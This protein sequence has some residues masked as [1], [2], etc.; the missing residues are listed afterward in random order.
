MMNDARTGSRS[1]RR[2]ALW[3]AVAT[4]L[5]GHGLLAQ[6]DASVTLAWDPSP[7][8]TV[9][10][11]IVHYGNASGQYSASTNVGNVTTATV[12]DLQVGT[13]YFFAVTAYDT[14]GLESDPSNEVSYTPT[15]ANAVTLVAVAS[16]TPASGTAPL[17]V[18]FDG[19]GSAV[20]G[21]SA[22]S[23][24]WTF[25]D[26]TTASGLTVQHTYQA[27]GPYTAVL[28]VTSGVGAT[29]LTNVVVSA[30]PPPMPPVAVA[31][32]TP[33]SGVVPFTVAFDGSASSAS[34]GSLVAYQWDFGD[35]TSA[36][37]ATVQHSY[38]TAGTYTAVLTVT[39]SRGASSTA[40]VVIN[41]QPAST[42]LSV[43]LAW[44]ASPD[45]TVAGYNVHY[46][47]ASGHY[48]TALNVGKQTTAQ[49]SGLQAGQTYFF[50]V[51]A[52]DNTGLES[53]PSNEVSYNPTAAPPK[54]TTPPVLAGVPANVTVQAG[55]LPTAPVVT[56]TDNADPAPVV[57]LTETKSAGT[58][59][60]SYQLVRTW[61]ATDAC[62]NHASASQTITVQD[63]TP[64][65]LAGVP[66]NVT[67][68]AGALPTA[69]LVTATDN[70]DPA[71]LV[72]LTETTVTNGDSQSY[73]LVRTWTAT[74]ACGNYASTAQTIT[75]QAV[76]PP[77]T[78]ANWELVGL[79]GTAIHFNSAALLSA[80]ASTDPTNWF[81]LASLANGSLAG[82][83]VGV[84]ADGTVS[85]LPPSGFAG[86]D[87]YYYSLSNSAGTTLSMTGSVQVVASLTEPAVAIAHPAG[88]A[89]VSLRGEVPLTATVDD[90]NG[91]VV[92]VE[93]YVHSSLVA[94]ATNRDGNSFS[95]VW[96]G[97]R[98]G[99]WP[100]TATA[101]T[102]DGR[103]VGSSPRKFSLLSLA[104]PG[105]AAGP[106]VIEES[107]DG[108]NWTVVKSFFSG[109][110]LS[111]TTPGALNFEDEQTGPARFY[112]V[113][114]L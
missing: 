89:V 11:Y 34:G 107:A 57:T 23:Y 60:Q 102:S 17:T 21:A 7:D 5:A 32:A 59:P 90:S 54:D 73:T 2:A 52:Y 55:A 6:T 38:L 28:T 74:D 30:L 62:G 24:Q 26:G 43:T 94:V 53:D 93:F 84:T 83:A 86:P 63:T 106:V 10:G 96:S 33:S 45:A 41:A 80:S 3:V 79:T 22:V 101:Y 25:G 56:A 111:D 40:T 113:R 87:S 72:T 15:N 64:P 99:F 39:D 81:V 31:T 61:T 16:A 91:V 27:A 114:S 69:P 44:D 14:S 46:G 92:R 68:Q 112:R 18:T 98:T 95:A 67:V 78:A 42:A 66:A 85:Y 29:S 49:V 35:A 9:A 4:L 47:T 51:T 109:A 50:V 37:G 110:A 65:V 58:C 97:A 103:I 19:S 100:L 36:T 8:S 105:I 108:R 13:P 12:G 48:T 104:H 76:T 70:A 20:A 77:V 88:A 75:V 71:P 82:G 1:I